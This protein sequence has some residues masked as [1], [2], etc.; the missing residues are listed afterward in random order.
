MAHGIKPNIACEVYETRGSRIEKR[1][2]GEKEKLAHLILLADNNE[3]YQN[4][5]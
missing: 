3:G 2:G 4:L 1:A 5:I